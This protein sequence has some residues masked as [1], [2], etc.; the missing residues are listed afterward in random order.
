MLPYETFRD[1]PRGFVARLAEFAEA[2]VDADFES[3]MVP[4]KGF[5]RMVE[6]RTSFLNP[7]VCRSS[8]NSY[9]TWAVP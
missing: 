5:P 4:N 2:E 7:F 6:Y 1:D 9:S 3:Q 8:V